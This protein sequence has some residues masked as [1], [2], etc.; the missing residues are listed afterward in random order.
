MNPINY[1][2]GQRGLE[3]F[4]QLILILAYLEHHF[5]KKKLF[6]DLN[7]ATSILIKH[8]SLLVF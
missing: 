8:L 5:I 1:F 2:Y 3:V 4:N 6:N 7:E